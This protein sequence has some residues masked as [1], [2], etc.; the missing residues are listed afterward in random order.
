MTGHLAI[1]VHEMSQTGEARRR[2]AALAERLGFNAEESGR[3][4]LVVTEAA[5]NLVKHAH[6]GEIVLSPSG[7]DEARAVE[8]L[9]MDRGPGIDDLER[10]LGDG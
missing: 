5:T 7:V 9:A 10:A 3:V 6:G 8:I 2:A 4:G 1:T